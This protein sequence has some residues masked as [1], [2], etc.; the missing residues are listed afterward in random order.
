MDA[1]GEAGLLVQAAE[2]ADGVDDFVFFLEGFTSHGLV[3]VI[4]GLLDLV[5]VVC[6]EIFTPHFLAVSLADK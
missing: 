6:N 5:G 3:K 1:V 4:E 2:A